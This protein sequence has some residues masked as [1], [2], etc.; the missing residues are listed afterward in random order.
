[1]MIFRASSFALRDA[2][3]D[4]LKGLRIAEEVQ[5]M[6]PLNVTPRKVSKLA[7]EVAL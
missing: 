2:F 6:E 4:V 7:E 5:D 1:M 3:G